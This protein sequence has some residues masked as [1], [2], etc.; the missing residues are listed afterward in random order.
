MLG[1]WQWVLHLFLMV[2][3]GGWTLFNALGWM[4]PRWRRYHLVCILLTAFAWL[5]LGLWYGIGYCP[6][7]DWH[8]QLLRNMG[9]RDLPPGFIEYFL[10]VVFGRR[11]RPALVHE[12]TAWWFGL[13]L[14]A[15]IGLNIRDSFRKYRPAR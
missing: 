14:L 15:S 8:W 2:F 10:E 12:V 13:A 11:L 1:A 6:L 9:V 3:H 5:G 7:T 4:A